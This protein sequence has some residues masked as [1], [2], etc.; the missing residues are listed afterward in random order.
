MSRPK[1][2]ERL[3]RLQQHRNGDSRNRR[4]RVLAAVRLPQNPSLPQPVLVQLAIGRFG[5]EDE[6]VVVVRPQ[7]TVALDYPDDVVRATTTVVDLS[8][9]ELSEPYA[10]SVYHTCTCCG[11][12][13]LSVA[14]A[15]QA[16]PVQV[17]ATGDVYWRIQ[18]RSPVDEAM[19]RVRLR[20]PDGAVVYHC[21]DGAGGLTRGQGS[22]L[23]QL[24][25]IDWPDRLLAELTLIDAAGR[26]SDARVLE[27]PVIRHREPP[28]PDPLSLVDR[29]LLFLALPF[30]VGLVGGSM[31][32]RR[33]ARSV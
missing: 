23:L 9:H 8:G 13:Q 18:A 32:G 12:D 31:L 21:V 6:Q 28:E 24:P 15:L 25:Q 1:R 4:R 11:P 7:T 16:E 10:A 22:Q 17:L 27:I 29:L 14:V 30:L 33:R 19:V 20:R 3:E 5:F 2:N 26:T